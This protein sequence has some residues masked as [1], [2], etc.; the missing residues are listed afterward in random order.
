MWHSLWTERPW[1]HSSK[2]SSQ[3]LER[4][5]KP[6]VALKETTDTSKILTHTFLFSSISFSGFLFT[7]RRSP[8][9][10]VCTWQNYYTLAFPPV[11]TRHNSIK[12]HSVSATS[13]TT[14]HHLMHVGLLQQ[15]S[16][17]S[18]DAVCDTNTAQRWRSSRRW[19]TCCHYYYYLL[20]KDSHY[21]TVIHAKL[22]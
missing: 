1:R 13:I 2:G 11:P 21:W 6:N 17:K 5:S 8:G 9:F 12:L 10:P 18:C 14:E 16:Q 15:C 7:G 19:Y 3:L 20:I 22:L 4:C